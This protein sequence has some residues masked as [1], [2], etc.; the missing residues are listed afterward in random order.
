[1]TLLA[2]DKP[3]SVGILLA[4][5]TI[6]IALLSRWLFKEARVLYSAEAVG[7]F[8]FD[9]LVVIKVIHTGM[10]SERSYILD[11][12][13]SQVLS[14]KTYVLSSLLIKIFKD[15]SRVLLQGQTSGALT[16]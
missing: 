16:N 14:L 12:L 10:P 11:M 3:K 6:V 13:R 5:G 1:V 15:I 7:H 9:K 4:T 8:S 2:L